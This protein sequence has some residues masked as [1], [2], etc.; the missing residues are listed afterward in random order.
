MI[1]KIKAP[2][3]KGHRG[4]SIHGMKGKNQALTAIKWRPILENEYTKAKL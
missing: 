1:I 4:G 3:S 2:E